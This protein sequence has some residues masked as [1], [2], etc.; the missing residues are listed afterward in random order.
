MR[1][2]Q[3]QL[4]PSGERLVDAGRR[5]APWGRFAVCLVLSGL[6]AS[7]AADPRG[8]GRGDFE[9]C[10]SCHGVRG[11]GIQ[12][13]QAPRIAGLDAAYVA[14]Q[15]RDFRQGRRGATGDNTPGAQMALMAK[16]LSD[17]AAIAQV[18][19]YVASLPDVRAPATVVGKAA[20]GRALSASCLGCHGA[21]GEGGVSAGVPRLA[22]MSDWY[23]LRQ[24][25]D[26][27]A[28]RR[29]KDGAEPGAAAMRAIALTLPTDQSLQ[30]VIAYINSLGMPA[31]VRLPDQDP[32]P[33]KHADPKH[34]DDELIACGC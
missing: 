32:A 24:L 27:R 31:S 20:A 25:E 4:N 6:A 11:E 29:G 33:Q 15:L 8:P 14:R 17:E 7:A 13:L 21:N 1:E 12:A 18:A 9:I 28:G 26:F 34:V 10:Q 5:A 3:Q 19:A 16:T 22:G 23:L 2:R 30:D